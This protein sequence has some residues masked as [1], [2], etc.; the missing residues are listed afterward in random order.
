MKSLT[1]LLALVCLSLSAAPVEKTAPKYVAPGDRLW[2]GGEGREWPAE[3]DPRW[4]G[5]SFPIPHMSLETKSNGRPSILMIGD[6][7]SDCYSQAAAHELIGKANVWKSGLRGRA[8]G[9]PYVF[10]HHNFQQDE[11]GALDYFDV[12][13][14]NCGLLLPDFNETGKKR[15]PHIELDAYE[16]DVRTCVAFLKKNFKGKLI[17]AT[18]TTTVS[19]GDVDAYNAIAVK[20]MKENGIAIN[21]LATNVGPEVAKLERRFNQL[22]FYKNE[23]YEVLGKAVVK[24][25]NAA[26][27]K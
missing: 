7:E 12:I 2:T 20:V 22:P 9:A 11:H 25:L 4:R 3:W 6:N 19:E 16:K 26:I 21:D 14:F 8:T 23:G 1:L 5:F 15:Q 24:S 18:M 27:G 13:H 17:F 10:S